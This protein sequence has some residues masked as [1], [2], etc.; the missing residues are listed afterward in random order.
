MKIHYLLTL[1]ISLLTIPSAFTQSLTSKEKESL[2]YEAGAFVKEL[3]LL[4]NN[5]SNDESSR[6]ERNT[7]IENSFSSIGNQIFFNEKVII[8]DDITPSHYNFENVVDL[9]VEKYLRNFDLFYK[10]QEYKS[11][12]FSD[13]YV[14]DV[15]EGSY[16]YLEVYFKSLFRGS[17][18]NYDLA[19]KSTSR[20]ATIIATQSGKKWDLKI[21]SIVFYDPDKHRVLF[22]LEKD[23]LE[24]NAIELDIETPSKAIS[25]ED[26]ERKTQEETVK[27]EVSSTNGMSFFA[28]ICL[29]YESNINKPGLGLSLQ[30]KPDNKNYAFYLEW[31]YLF[32][33]STQDT[34]NLQEYIVNRFDISIG[35]TYEFKTSINTFKPFVVGGINYTQSIL[36]ATESNFE[37]AP[38][39]SASGIELGGGIS[40][41]KS[42][43]HPLNFNSRISYITGKASRFLIQFGVNYKINQK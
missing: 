9:T 31:R 13:F 25:E 11:I 10:K 3:E 14:S 39:A 35:A 24:I 38:K 22:D 28:G 2:R 41:K 20:V 42:P 1:F 30:A 29:A 32:S 18:V 27:N 15:K 37:E 6:L 36:R 16:I 5:I 7:V 8:E 21:A 33:E 19:Y 40:Y 17:H 34:I 12:K 4:L 43:N 26:I 23:P